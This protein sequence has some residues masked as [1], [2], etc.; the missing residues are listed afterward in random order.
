[1]SRRIVHACGYWLTVNGVQS[2]WVP[3]D[4]CGVFTR[5]GRNVYP[6][7]WWGVRVRLRSVPG[8]TGVTCP[9]CRFL[10]RQDQESTVNAAR[11]EG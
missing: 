5:C 9:K 8:P 7:A 3:S 4:E 11:A 6:K 10:L 2:A 1:M